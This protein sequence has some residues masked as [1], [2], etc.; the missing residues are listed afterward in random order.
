MYLKAFNQVKKRTL[1][2]ER[3]RETFIWRTL[4]KKGKMNGKIYILEL[5]EASNN[6]KDCFISLID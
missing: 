5:V 2:S 3:Q 1:F 4:K 6:E